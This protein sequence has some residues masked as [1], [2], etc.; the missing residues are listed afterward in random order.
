MAKTARDILRSKGSDIWS[1]PPEATVYEALRLM[2][3]K[4]IGAVLVMEGD[5]LLGIF[6][7]RDYARKVDLLGKRAADTPVQ[8]IM[9]G[10]V[11]CVRPDETIEECMA[12]MTDKRV[13]HLPVVEDERVVG[14]VSIGDVVKAIIS[15]QEFIIE[16]L[17]NYIT[18]AHLLS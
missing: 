14:L 12:L 7:E 17:E 15:E 8:T 1:V 10:R 2:A 18:G 9:T 4:N 6:S 11:V 5:R 13:R 16:Q 3:D